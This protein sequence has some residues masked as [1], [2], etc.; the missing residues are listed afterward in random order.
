ML[1]T[2]A[3][4]RIAHAANE[5]GNFARARQCYEQGAA[6]GDAECLQALGYM[7]DVGEGVAVDKSLAM[8]LYR[9]AW[10]RGSHAAGT[11]IAILYQEQGKFGMMFRGSNEWLRLG[12]VALTLRWRSVTSRG[13]AFERIHKRRCNA[14]RL[15]KRRCTPLNTNGRKLALC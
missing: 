1:N 9:K 6:I 7:Y 15:R 2:D 8:K 11:N 10:R 14:S 13:A 12:T 4:L 5:E 3:L